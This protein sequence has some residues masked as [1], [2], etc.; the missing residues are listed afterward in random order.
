ILLE[1]LTLAL[2]LSGPQAYI[3][4]KVMSKYKP[5]SISE[6]L[7]YIESLAEES[8]WDREVKR[9][10]LRKIGILAEKYPVVFSKSKVPLIGET[11]DIIVVDASALKLT[12][13]RKAFSLLVLASE[14]YWRVRGKVRVRGLYVVDEAHNLMSGDSSLV[15]KLTAESRKY[16]MSLLLITQSPYASEP[17]LLNTSTKIVHAL[18]SSRDKIVIGDSLGLGRD[19]IEALGRLGVGEAL[20]YAPSIKKPLFVKVELVEPLAE[21]L[22]NSGIL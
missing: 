2:D 6:L 1:V 19:E 13:A 12:I 5:E 16:G 21:S 8:K 10:L 3:L 11:S 18:R 14:Y 22:N 20:V 15:E 7:D 9:G 4:Q 17:I